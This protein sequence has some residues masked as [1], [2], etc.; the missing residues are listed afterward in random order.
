[1]NS[2]D[3]LS[4]NLTRELSPLHFTN[5]A[6]FEDSSPQTSNW[7]SGGPPVLLLPTFFPGLPE[8]SSMASAHEPAFEAFTSNMTGLQAHP[9]AIYPSAATGAEYA[10]SMHCHQTDQQ[11]VDCMQV[12][13]AASFHV[14]GRQAIALYSPSDESRLTSYQILIRE[15]IELFEALPGDVDTTTQG[16]ARR[17]VLGQVGIRCR[18]CAFLPAKERKRAAVYYPSR[19]DVVYQASCAGRL[20]VFSSPSMHRLAPN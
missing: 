2:V 7:D 13:L 5:M 3:D 19:L 12:L 10:N 11:R 9:Q 14:T 4:P 16:Q 20:V 1:M 17:V 6:V 15:Q 8:Q 18:H